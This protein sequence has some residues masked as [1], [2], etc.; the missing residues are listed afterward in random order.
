MQE[1]EEGWLWKA[2]SL[3]EKSVVQFNTRRAKV[4]AARAL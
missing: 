1:E 4:N 3:K 2:S